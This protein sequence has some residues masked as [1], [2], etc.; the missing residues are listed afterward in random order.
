MIE[1]KFKQDESLG[2]KEIK[3]ILAYA[4]F[5][6]AIFELKQLMRD[7]WETSGNGKTSEEV[8]K[9]KDQFYEIVSGLPELD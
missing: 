1:L 6:C 8:D 3:C 4:D 9:F 2:D 7:F 5:P